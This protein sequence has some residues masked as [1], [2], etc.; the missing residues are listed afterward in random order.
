MPKF[1]DN[2]TER[3]QS[4]RCASHLRGSKGMQG[5][6]SLEDVEVGW[7]D[8]FEI[9]GVLVGSAQQGPGTDGR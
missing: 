1:E 4:V 9:E 6:F 8:D 5:T 7:C 3:T 2:G